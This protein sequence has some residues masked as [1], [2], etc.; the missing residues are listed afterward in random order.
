M[1][2]H[3]FGVSLARSFKVSC[4]LSKVCPLI[5]K[6][7]DLKDIN[8]K[9]ITS[10]ILTE[11]VCTINKL[12]SVGVTVLMT[13]SYREAMNHNFIGMVDGFISSLYHV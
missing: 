1:D 12:T 6:F 8:K 5:V 4:L 11:K 9:K 10:T 3:N 7:T 13:P 2:I